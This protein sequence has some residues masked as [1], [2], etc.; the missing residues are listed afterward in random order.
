MGLNESRDCQT[1]YAAWLSQ[2]GGG[3][4]VGALVSAKLQ[5]GLKLYLPLFSNLYQHHFLFGF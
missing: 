4:G 2:R 1:S 3:Q 5:V